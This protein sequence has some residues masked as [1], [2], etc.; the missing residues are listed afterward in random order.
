MEAALQ[1][2]STGDAIDSL[3][4]KTYQLVA[5]DRMHQIA[6]IT[7]NQG[8]VQEYGSGVNSIIDLESL[9]AFAGELPSQ[10]VLARMVKAKIVSKY[11]EGVGE[12]VIRVEERR[13]SELADPPVDYGMF[14]GEIREG[15]NDR[16]RISVPE[17]TVPGREGYGKHKTELERTVAT[18]IERRLDGNYGEIIEV[19]ELAGF[20]MDTLDPE[21]HY[22]GNE[23]DLA[24]GSRGEIIEVGADRY[25][26]MVDSVEWQLHPDEVTLTGE[27]KY[28]G[29]DVVKVVRDIIQTVEDNKME[30]HIAGQIAAINQNRDRDLDIRTRI[31]REE[32][33]LSID[34]ILAMH[35]EE[36]FEYEVPGLPKVGPGLVPFSDLYKLLAKAISQRTG[37]EILG[38][39]DEITTSGEFRINVTEAA[40]HLGVDNDLVL[41]VSSEVADI[42]D[43]QHYLK[44]REYAARNGAKDVTRAMIE[45]MLG[46]DGLPWTRRLVLYANKDVYEGGDPFAPPSE[47]LFRV[48]KL[49]VGGGCAYGKCTFCMEYAGA[50]FFVHKQAKFEAHARE[51]KRL[52]GSDSEYIRRV[53]LSGGDTFALPTKR[54][55]G[56]LSTVNELFNDGYERNIRRVEAFSRTEGI[57]R[58]SVGEIKDLVDHNLR[59]LYWGAETGSDELLAYVN[60]GITRAKMDKAIAKLTST[61]MMVSIMIMPGLGGMRFYDQHVRET[62]ALVN[63]LKPRWTTF[64]TITP[65][66]GARYGKI[67]AEEMAAGTN[68]PLT[69]EE[70]VEQMHDIVAGMR[71]GYR[72]LVAT[73]YPPSAKI[74][75][76]PV[77]FRGYMHRGN[78]QFGILTELKEWFSLGERVPSQDLVDTDFNKGS[79]IRALARGGEAW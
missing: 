32:Y 50:P 52:L 25:S 27:N 39:A 46:R 77:T 2:P 16:F 54:L 3:L 35:R 44:G 21:Y 67:M 62:V 34:Q 59:L 20:D 4:R 71:T 22:G 47:E 7:G 12:E 24:L 13:E 23:D 17:V 8:L 68:R 6:E 58:K 19:T 26:V 76:N 18:E 49:E 75:I 33:G 14:V 56:Y 65:K 60:K 31:F 63:A 1:Q 15:I 73:Y 74:A 57:T 61:S 51:V 5:Q 42:L 70:V 30:A 28:A 64:H 40:D 48:I 11:G 43:K 10:E 66:P 38:G 72:N 29:V 78:G 41:R 45:E 37:K 79:G 36:D 53:F 55:K 69:E 9:F